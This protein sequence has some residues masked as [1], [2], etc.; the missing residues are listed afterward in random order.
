LSTEIVVKN[1]L[2]SIV[3]FILSVE[4]VDYDRIN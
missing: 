1:N 4:S 3:C 2:A